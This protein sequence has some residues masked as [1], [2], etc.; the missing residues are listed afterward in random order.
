M[1]AQQLNDLWEKKKLKIAGKKIDVYKHKDFNVIRRKRTFNGLR[2]VRFWDKPL[3]RFMS[4]NRK[5]LKVLEIGSHEGQSTSWFFQHI[6]NNHPSNE[7]ICVDP[8]FISHWGGIS[9]YDILE[10]RVKVINIVCT[11]L[12]RSIRSVASIFVKTY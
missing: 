11:F 6:I 7:M 10:K 8:R 12:Y 1:N 9:Y 5:N 3:K 2:C 4:K